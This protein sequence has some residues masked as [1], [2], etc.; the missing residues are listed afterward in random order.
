MV[1]NEIKQAFKREKIHRWDHVKIRFSWINEEE[2]VVKTYLSA[3]ALHADWHGECEHCP[4]NDAEIFD[5]QI[6]TSEI[7]NEAVPGFRFEELMELIENTWR[8]KKRGPGVSAD[9]AGQKFGRL[10][11]IRPTEERKHGSVV[12]ECK[13]NC[14]CGNT[15]FVPRGSLISGCT[16]SCGCLN[17]KSKRSRAGSKEVTV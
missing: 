4:E 12:W 13:C 1:S 14:E 7:P 16:R 17:R 2:A 15:K 10:T 11:A 8:R 3:Y 5:I 6:G 9:I